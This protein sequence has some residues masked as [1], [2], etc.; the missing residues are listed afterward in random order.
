MNLVVVGLSHH[1]SPLELRERLAF[2]NAE[3]P[4][5]LLRLHKGLGGAGVVILSTCNRVE[6]Y[7]HHT[8]EPDE[9]RKEIRFFLSES[10]CVPEEA[11]R[12]ALYEYE[13][14]EAVG[15]LFRV[16]SSLDSMVVGEVQ[17]L[18]QVHDAYIAAQ[19]EQT[20]DKVIHA[21]FQ[22]AFTVAKNVRTQTTIG[23]GKV[24]VSSVA[25]DLAESIFQTLSGKTVMVIG[26]GEMAEL[27]LKSLVSRGVRSVLIVNR[28]AERAR[29]LAE[30]YNGEAIAF[31]ELNNH[32]HRAEIVMSATAAPRFILHPPSFHHALKLRGQ[33]PMFVIDIAVPRD[34]DPSV[35]EIDNVYL[36]NI[37]DLEHV[38]AENLEL[39]RKEIDRSMELVEHGVNQFMQWKDTLVAEPTFVSMTEELNTIRER[40]LERTLKA[41]PD[42]TET[43]RQEVAALSKRIVKNIL[44]RSMVEIKHEIGHHDPHTVLHLVKRFFGLRE[45]T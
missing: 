45:T 43:Q 33:Q 8:M 24:S 2:S 5:A 28:N 41:L 35:A 39:R 44:Q 20:A 34:V 11:F 36:Y 16:A 22:K 19:A 3:L 37:D 12:D 18:G 21:L 31:E 4:S 30:P 14:R 40:E 13:N 29:A 10:H 15:H 25:V 17:I 38:V 32:L 9:L 23:E 7:T 42:L 6:I 1:T 27:T 26:S